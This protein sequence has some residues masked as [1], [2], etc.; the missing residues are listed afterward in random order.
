MQSKPY[1][2]LS[3]CV[4]G[5]LHCFRNSNEHVNIFNLTPSDAI[6]VEEIARVIVEEMK[7]KEVAF[8]FAGGERGWN[9]DVPRVRL[10]GETLARLGW[11]AKMSSEQAVR[12][13]VR[14]VLSNDQ[15]PS[16]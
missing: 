1:L 14:E 9:G 7:L 4:D 13:A 8:H 15:P 5:I 6:S 12:S 16:T 3:E 2:H 11:K 10:N